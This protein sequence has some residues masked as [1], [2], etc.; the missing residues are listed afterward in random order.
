MAFE[1]TSVRLWKRL[2]REDRLGAS[3]A[4]WNDPP[5]ALVGSALGAIAKARH[6]RPQVARAMGL[7]ERA[8]A[9]ASI[10]DP[11]EVLAATLLVSLHLGQRRALLGAFLD[12]VGLP[13]E[14][15]VLKDEQDAGAPILDA[16]ARQAVAA[17][18][19]SHPRDQV[20]T[21]LNTLWLQD[22]TRWAALAEAP[23]WLG[24]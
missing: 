9:L 4:F 2:S 17:V 19:A 18:A 14:D 11:G 16:R 7:D 1:T 22:P 21:Y 3:T 6:L 10:L 8:R 12:A 5:E 24:A 15:G 23:A 13:H 20:L